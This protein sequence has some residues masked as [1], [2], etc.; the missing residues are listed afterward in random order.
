LGLAIGD[1]VGATL[2]FQQRDTYEPLNDM[3]GA[4]CWKLKPVQWTDDTAMSLALADS[5]HEKNGLDER[6]LLGRFVEL[7]ERGT[8]LYRTCR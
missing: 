4:G 2:E 5:L 1:G 3:I 7:W 6:D 8:F